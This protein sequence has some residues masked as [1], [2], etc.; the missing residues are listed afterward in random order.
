VAGEGSVINAPNAAMGPRIEGV[1]HLPNQA[2][3]GLAL[4]LRMDHFAQLAPGA[5]YDRSRY[6]LLFGYAYVPRGFRRS[7]GW[8]VF[9]RVGGARGAM[10]G[11]ESTPVAFS[12]GATAGLPIRISPSHFGEDEVLRFTFMFVPQLD[13]G[14]AGPVE[15]DHWQFQFG[16]SLGIRM[17]FDSTLLP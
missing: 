9:G 1:M 12:A 11:A 4:G 13:V 7:W 8:E 16:G 15:S 10:G 3:D 17:H 2:G 6:E 14:L 5:T